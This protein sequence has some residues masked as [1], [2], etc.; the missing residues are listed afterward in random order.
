MICID[1]LFVISF[2]ILVFFCIIS[3]IKNILIDK[4]DS[5]LYS[6]SFEKIQK[7]KKYFLFIKNITPFYSYNNK[8]VETV[9]N[10]LESEIKRKKENFGLIQ[11]EMK[12]AKAYISAP[13]R[14][15]VLNTYFENNSHIKKN[16]CIMLCEVNKS[17]INLRAS[18]SGNILYRVTEGE[19]FVQGA[20]LA[21]IY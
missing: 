7:Y 18:C 12:E 15:K 6:F 17:C 21:E 8:D 19:W 1:I 11:N 20:L 4:V 2:L 16:D 13:S 14:G 3:S 5:Q 9:L 10:I